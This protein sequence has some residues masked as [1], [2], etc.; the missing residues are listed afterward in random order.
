MKIFYL[1][2]FIISQYVEAMEFDL[3]SRYFVLGARYQDQNRI[4][5][6]NIPQPF[7]SK[8]L[9]S[10]HT[11]QYDASNKIDSVNVRRGEGLPYSTSN[12]ESSIINF[13]T[14]TIQDLRMMNECNFRYKEL[15]LLNVTPKKFNVVKELI[16]KSLGDIEK[17]G[18][19]YGE[20][21]TFPKIVDEFM[22]DIASEG[23]I[24]V[25]KL[26]G[27]NWPCETAPLAIRGH[28]KSTRD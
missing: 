17:I 3:D 5:S 22:F 6:D 2:F 25:E 28:K 21:K 15:Y 18:Y 20:I 19:S 23:K 26:N 16:S 8:I 12:D 24:L 9:C 1:L 13:S 11:N 4:H 14:K 27:K 10:R 7:T